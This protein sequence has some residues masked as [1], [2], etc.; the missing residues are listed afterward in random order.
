MSRLPLR[1]IQFDL[2]ERDAE[3]LN[4]VAAASG[5]PK[6][7]LISAIVHGWLDR[8]EPKGFNDDAPSPFWSK[9]QQRP[10]S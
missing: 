6:N 2:D 7:R 1:H 5:V 9:L 4:V 3:R 8:L 10:G